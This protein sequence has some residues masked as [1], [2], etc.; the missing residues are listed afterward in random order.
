MSEAV[1][2]TVSGQ[3]TRRLARE[4]RA[5]AAP[6]I[7]NSLLQTMVLVVDRAMLGH[8]ADASLAG[9]QIAGPIEWSLW[10]IFSAFQVGTI[11]RVGRHVGAGDPALAQRA[12][13][14]SLG[15]ALAAGVLVAIASPAVT[16]LIPFASPHASRPVILAA[17]DYLSITMVASPVVFAG[18]TAIATLQASGDTRTPLYIGV[19]VNLL[20]VALNRVLILGAFGV[21]ALG[22]RGAAI[23]TAI[24]FGLEAALAV[25]LLM[26][27]GRRASLRGEG[28]ATREEYV[29]EARSVGHIAVPA[30][31][32]RLLYHGGYLGFVA[33]IALLGDGPMAANQALI[34]VESICFLSAD[35]FG[36]AAAA[37]V[38]QKLGAGL[39]G[40]AERAARLS[41]RYAVILLTTLGLLALAFRRPALA[42]FSSDPY[43][44]AIG[45]AAVPV[46]ACA[47]PFMAVGSVLAQSLRGAGHTRAVLGVSAVG[48]FVVRLSCTWIF[49]ITLGWGL[50]GVWI[51]STCD[52]AVRSVL[53]VVIG[54]RYARRG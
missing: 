29:R 24:T 19:G 10:S 8:H 1:S 17:R 38:A 3:A 54:R 39:P 13:R 49:A 41:S 42:V 33:I 45:V 16:A 22:P 50:T 32:E 36:I 25:M 12:A 4:V 53:L 37:L 52:W 7:A 21:P 34:S 11:A 9:M 2:G 27:P 51:G 30:L 6:A 35:G 31:L 28:R 47:Q 26:R 23:S 46:L 15:F 44:V 48:A 18:A 40:D 20:H 5:L 14:V 43:V